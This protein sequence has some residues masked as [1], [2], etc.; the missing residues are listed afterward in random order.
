MFSLQLFNCIYFAFSITLYRYFRKKYFQ[1]CYRGSVSNH[2]PYQITFL[3]PTCASK[4]SQRCVVMFA[5]GCV[6]SGVNVP[7]YIVNDINN[8]R[9]IISNHCE[10]FTTDLIN[11]KKL[12]KQFIGS[13]R[14]QNF[15]SLVFSLSVTSSIFSFRFVR[16]VTKS[17]TTC[18]QIDL[19]VV[20]KRKLFVICIRKCIIMERLFK[21]F[22]IS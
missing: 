2:L 17:Y 8:S 16:T 20:I 21:V 7:L 4:F 1:E 15:L 12:S 14:N 3:S 22:V 18:S 5:V 13:F 9:N 10:F 19:M 6:A 11:C